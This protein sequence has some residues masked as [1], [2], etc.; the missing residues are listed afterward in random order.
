[1][2]NYIWGILI[3]ISIIVGAFTG[4]ISNVTKAAIESSKDAITLALTMLGILAMWS[5]LMRVAET[6]GIIQA[7]TKKLNPILNFLFPEIPKNHE[8]RK[9]IATNIVANMLGLG[10]AATPPGLKAMESLQKINPDKSQ[11]SVSM[12]TF[13][14]I[15]ISSVQIISINMIAYRLQYGSVN[16]TEIIGPS[17]IATLLSTVVGVIYAK[18]MARTV[19]RNMGG[20]GK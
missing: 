5:G 4:N 15:N 8:S 6:A 12:C 2:L 20:H 10:W 1:M 13:L 16:P 17:L 3:I 18:I 9:Y 19:P 7:L 14:I 11:A